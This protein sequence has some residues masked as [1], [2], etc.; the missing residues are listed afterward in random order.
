MPS[1]DFTQ[2]W[3][4]LRLP[5]SLPQGAVDVA[6]A[7]ALMP[8]ASAGGCGCSPR[9]PTLRSAVERHRNARLPGTKLTKTE[10]SRKSETKRN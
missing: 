7:L 5:W 3:V 10:W 2:P 8:L 4:E 6:N 1:P 9:P